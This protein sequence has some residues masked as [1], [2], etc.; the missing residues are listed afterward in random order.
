MK[1]ESF[2]G[3]LLGIVIMCAVFAFITIAW[4]AFSQ[5]LTIGGTATVAA[6]KWN[7]TF[8]DELNKDFATRLGEVQ[9]AG[10]GSETSIPLTANVNSTNAVAGDLAITA[11]G[12]VSGSIGTF[13]QKD[14]EITY[15]W[16]AQ[17]FGT[18]DANITVSTAGALKASASGLGNVSLTCSK[19]TS[20]DSG[21]AQD[22]CNS[23]L[24]ATLYV[25][26][27][28]ASDT[29]VYT[30]DFASPG[31]DIK[32]AG[33]ADVSSVKQYAYQFKLVVKFT[34]SSSVETSRD[35]ISVNI[36]NIV[37]QADQATTGS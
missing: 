4:A 14:D 32:K 9:T 6:Q 5:T 2:Q 1:R 36:S 13:N 18:F 8:T 19:T 24:T 3:I 29:T 28:G 20:N 30:S 35:E 7:I 33:T 12:V 22:W 17:N 10:T 27:V 25:N 16:Y 31:L 21:T 26:K 34:G 15:T 37:L 23:N 11:K